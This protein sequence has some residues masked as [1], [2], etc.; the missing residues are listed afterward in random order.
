MRITYTPHA[1]DRMRERHITQ[2]DVREVLTNYSSTKTSA[3]G[4]TQYIGLAATGKVNVV[5]TVRRT[6]E[7]TY[8][9]YTVF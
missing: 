3:K 8:H 2:D 1:R 5:A 9:V 4:R 7:D 6:A